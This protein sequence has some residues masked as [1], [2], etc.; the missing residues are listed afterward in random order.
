MADKYIYI[1]NVATGGHITAQKRLLPLKKCS[2]GDISVL[3]VCVFFSQVNMMKLISFLC[4]FVLFLFFK[5][6]TSIFSLE[7][8]QL[9]PLF[10]HSAD[11]APSFPVY[12]HNVGSSP[13]IFVL[14]RLPS[15]PCLLL[16]LCTSHAYLMHSSPTHS[17]C[18]ALLRVTVLYAQAENN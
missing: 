8:S 15:C 9:P 10:I 6:L 7:H 13:Q 12:L 16:P 2:D 5:N 17:I 11:V 3:A 14:V 4:Q 18:W 1:I